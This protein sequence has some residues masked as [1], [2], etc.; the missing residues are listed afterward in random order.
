MVEAIASKLPGEF[1]REHRRHPAG[2]PLIIRVRRGKALAFKVEVRI[3]VPPAAPAEA[4]QRASAAPV[5]KAVPSPEIAPAARVE[6]REYRHRGHW[7]RQVES[8]T[9]V[10]RKI[11]TL[12]RF[13][14]CSGPGVDGYINRESG[15]FWPS[16][17]A[18]MRQLD[19]SERTVSSLYAW[20]IK[21]EFVARAAKGGNGQQPSTS[22]RYR[23]GKHG[24]F[25]SELLA[26]LPEVAR[27]VAGKTAGSSR[28]LPAKR[29]AGKNVEKLN[30]DRCI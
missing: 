8:A 12:A 11:V 2:A 23:R 14:T 9:G 13:L 10:P 5:G 19:C 30:G 26:K 21:N 18:V 22:S 16:V 20:L 27:K 28:K 4:V 15:E 29:V 6:C 3:G 7:R 25:S 17:D 24:P 1:E